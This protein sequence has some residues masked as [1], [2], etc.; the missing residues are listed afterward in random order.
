MEPYEKYIYTGLISLFVGLLL[1]RLQAKAKLKYFLPGTFFYNIEDPKVT[2]RTDSVTIQNFGRKPASNIEI[3][4]K[5]K[6][7]HFQFS[8]AVDYSVGYNPS[9]NHV[10]KIENLGPKEFINIQFLSHATVPELLNIRS[11]DGGAKEIKVQFQQVFPMWFY[12]ITSIFLLIGLGQTL[13]WLFAF[14]VKL[15]GG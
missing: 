7:D 5:V 15:V 9:G 6:P 3:I 2:I 10:I 11:E 1:Q 4:H 14:V 12:I 8:Q 13:S